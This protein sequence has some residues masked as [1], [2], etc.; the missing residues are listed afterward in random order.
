MFNSKN[1]NIFY[2]LLNDVCEIAAFMQ[3]TTFNS[4]KDF[5]HLKT[6]KIPTSKY[7]HDF[8]SRTLCTLKIN[9]GLRQGKIYSTVDFLGLHGGEYPTYYLP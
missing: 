5:F 8:N 1:K 6:R 3:M 9:M 4:L 2:A 7:L